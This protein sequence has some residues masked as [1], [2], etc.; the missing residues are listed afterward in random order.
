MTVG[1][2]SR[3]TRD[4]IRQRRHHSSVRLPTA[5]F[6]V[7][8]SIPVCQVRA[9]A[10]R[11]VD[12][13]LG[14]GAV[15]SKECVSRVPHQSRLGVSHD[16]ADEHVLGIRIPRMH[17]AVCERCDGSLWFLVRLLHEKSFQIYSLSIGE[18]R[19]YYCLVVLYSMKNLPRDVQVMIAERLDPKSSARLRAVS[20]EMKDVVNATRPPTGSYQKKT[21]R[22]QKR[23]S[24]RGME[25]C[26]KK[27]V[28]H[29]QGT[30]ALRH[31]SH[32]QEYGRMVYKRMKKSYERNTLFRDFRSITAAQTEA[33]HWH[34][35]L[36]L[37]PEADPSDDTLRRDMKKAWLEETREKKTF[38]RRVARL[39]RMWAADGNDTYAETLKL[40]RRRVVPYTDDEER[41]HKDRLM[42]AIIV[43][44]SVLHAADDPTKRIL[45]ND[46]TPLSLDQKIAL[47]VKACST[48]VRV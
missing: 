46:G 48:S 23:F 41:R 1:Y 14:Q 3:R 42:D 28:S 26:A 19:H 9:A 7:E 47:V 34:E 27:H 22:F 38:R 25:K 32:F 11:R 24:I 35:M 31:Y 36:Q 15:W 44:T 37:F 30:N 10:D 5:A 2:P 13:R 45:G 12:V 33:E 40:A 6:T 17:S 20:T 16:I 8:I 29:F 4:S 18:S 21:G 39:L 43:Q